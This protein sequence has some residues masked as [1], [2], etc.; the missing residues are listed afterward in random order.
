MNPPNSPVIVLRAVYIADKLEGSK[1][2]LLT[3]DKAGLKEITLT[4]FFQQYFEWKN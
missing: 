1:S 2:S 3:I 4:L